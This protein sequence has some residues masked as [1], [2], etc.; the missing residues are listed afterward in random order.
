MPFQWSFAQ[1]LRL[2][3]W[4]TNKGLLLAAILLI[5]RMSMA[6]RSSRNLLSSAAVSLAWSA[7][8]VFAKQKNRPTALS[9]FL[10]TSVRASIQSV[11]WDVMPLF[12]KVVRIFKMTLSSPTVF[13]Y[14]S[15]FSGPCTYSPEQRL[16]VSESRWSSRPIIPKVRLRDKDWR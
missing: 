9:T 16:V 6:S 4:N 7:F 11:L 12:M 1:L 14:L 8:T 10:E 15:R 5:A 2:N 13:V 3:G